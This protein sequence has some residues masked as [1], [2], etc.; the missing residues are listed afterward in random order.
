MFK[1]TKTY[2]NFEGVTATE[3]FWFNLNE[4]ELLDSENSDKPMSQT[5]IHIM[6]END[7]NKLIGYYK[8]L[9][10]MSYG[11]R[12]DA[13]HFY[14]SPEIRKSLESHV[15]FSDIY[16][17]LVS[18]NTGEKLIAFIKG[19]FPKRMVADMNFDMSETQVK[20]MMDKIKNGE[21]PAVKDNVVPMS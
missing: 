1:I 6:R 7:I 8:D 21:I 19:V 15:A 11:E 2:E 5:L 3:D 4:T 18:D 9:L 12:R 10:L 20:E 14:K 17:D 16:M 13:S